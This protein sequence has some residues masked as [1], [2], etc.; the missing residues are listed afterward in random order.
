MQRTVRRV[1]V[2]CSRT[3]VRPLIEVSAPHH[4]SNCP[5][6]EPFHPDEWTRVYFSSHDLLL[7]FHRVFSFA[8]SANTTTNLVY[9]VSSLASAFGPR[10]RVSKAE[11]SDSPFLEI[12]LDPT[13][14]NPDRPT[15]AVVPADGVFF[16]FLSPGEIPFPSRHPGEKNFEISPGIRRLRMSLIITA[17]SFPLFLH[18]RP[19]NLRNHFEERSPRRV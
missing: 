18:C 9:P 6:N 5:Y 4:H 11:Q 15:S 10:H 17:A 3:G 14:L 12:L 8:C 1:G 16:L 2:R 19:C 7:S 13:F